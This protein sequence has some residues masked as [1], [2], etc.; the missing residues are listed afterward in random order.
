MTEAD[1]EAFLA[2][3]ACGGD[4]SALDILMSLHHDVM[5]T[6]DAFILSKLETKGLPPAGPA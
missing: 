3:E 5:E 1:R 4:L 6:D 2:L